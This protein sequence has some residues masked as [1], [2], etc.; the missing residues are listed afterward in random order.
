MN[1]INISKIPAITGGETT[2][3]AYNRVSEYNLHD[4][5]NLPQPDRDSVLEITETAPSRAPSGKR[6]A[7]RIAFALLAIGGS[8][9]GTA[10]W[11][12]YTSDRDR[13]VVEHHLNELEACYEDIVTPEVHDVATAAR[14]REACVDELFN[15]TDDTQD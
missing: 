13:E 9:A 8:L 7:G 1:R 10:G 6:K 3:E 12:K 2:E 15:R 11:L 5:F 14:L 4:F